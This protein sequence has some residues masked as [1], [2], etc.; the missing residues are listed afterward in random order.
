VEGNWEAFERW[1][2]QLRKELE[3]RPSSPLLFRGQGNFEWPLTTTL[4]RK[5][6]GSMSFGAYYRL[7]TA[8]IGPAV[9]TL[10][11]VSVPEYDVE[12]AK[13]CADLEAFSPGI[14]SFPS[15]SLYRYMIYLRH[16]GFPS[17]LLDWSYS[18][19]VAAFFAFSGEFSPI[20]SL[21]FPD[22]DHQ[23]S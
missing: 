21:N 12:F 16:H 11:G 18:P 4:E 10:T 19:Y 1:L 6:K 22:P 3:N 23:F 5:V 15:V 17:P 13:R 7:I 2:G 9:E 20:R 8:R 14:G